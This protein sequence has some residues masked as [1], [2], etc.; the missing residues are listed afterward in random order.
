MEIMRIQPD[1]K[2]LPGLAR[3]RDDDE[4][5]I[6]ARGDA[7]GTERAQRV[8]PRGRPRGGLAGELPLLRV[9]PS[10]DAV[11]PPRDERSALRP[12]E[13]E[14]EPRRLAQDP[15]QPAPRRGPKAHATVRA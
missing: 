12:R 10:D 2:I 13:R 9:D 15:R 8:E 4:P 3:S 5:V 6:G 11:G 7:V 1:W 14:R